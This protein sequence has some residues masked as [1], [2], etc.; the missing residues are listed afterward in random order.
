M[1]KETET[2]MDRYS[3]ELAI[4]WPVAVVP[5]PA[6]AGAQI[7]VDRV[8][9]RHQITIPVEADGTYEEYDLAH[10]LVHAHL[11]ESYDPI[12]STVYFDPALDTS[13]PV[14][15]RKMHAVALAQEVVDVWVDD[16]VERMDP[17]LIARSVERWMVRIFRMQPVEFADQHAEVIMGFA[18][19][20]QQIRR[21][22][23]EELKQRHAWA[24]EKL[25]VVIG[26]GDTA[27]AVRL[28]EYMSRLPRL[29]KEPKHALKV[30]ETSTQAVARSL[31][32]P[33][34]PRLVRVEDAWVW[35]IA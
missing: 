11:A 33:V 14:V 12:F 32:L 27:L 5:G 23:L 31:R 24:R 3:K 17:G 25:E 34:R 26:P 9:H 13:D 21:Y 18:H 20:A 4:R 8:T 30:F 15:Q 35:A 29:P 22:G 1:N 7:F 19:N 2:L 6:W 16:I 28:G 10:E